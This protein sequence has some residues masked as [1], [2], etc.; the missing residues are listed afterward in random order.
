MNKSITVILLAIS[1]LFINIA[2]AAEAPSCIMLK[3]T[4]DTRFD[5]ID[6]AGTLSDMVMEK[7]LNSGKINFRET[8]VIDSNLE[9]LLYN[10]NK[11]EFQQAQE[12]LRGAEASMLFEGPVFAEE[13]ANS[14]DTA[15]LGQ[16][17]SPD[18]IRNIGQQNG[19]EYIIQ[20][21]ILNIGAGGWLNEDITK[22][23]MY[24]T[25]AISLAAMATATAGQTLGQIPGLGLLDGLEVTESGIGIQADIRII[26]VDTGE[27]VWQKR[28]LGKKMQQQVGVGF[29]KVG[30]GKLSN[31]IYYKAMEDAATK[32][33]NA[34]IADATNGTLFAK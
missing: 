10:E 2:E 18:V 23:V 1:I 16:I 15:R 21:T 26:K 14:I 12:V 9:E 13:R 28:L 5:R 29:L 20:G 34:I 7:L 8:R 17:V 4:D 3:F 27:V 25:D 24:A 6:S 31:D 11:L 19:A 22:G 32:F 30:S 33:A